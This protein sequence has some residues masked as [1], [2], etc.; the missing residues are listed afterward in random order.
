[1]PLFRDAL[2]VFSNFSGTLIEDSDSSNTISSVLLLHNWNCPWGYNFILNEIKDHSKFMEV[3]FCYLTRDAD[4]AAEWLPTQWIE[5]VWWCNF[6]VI[7]KL[8]LFFSFGQI[9][10]LFSVHILAEFSNSGPSSWCMLGESLRFKCQLGPC[11]FVRSMLDQY[12]HAG[13]RES[14][15]FKIRK[16]RKMYKFDILIAS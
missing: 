6:D 10:N 1:M 14:H 16:V 12:G 13:C 3:R 2:R 11:R 4:H 7:V 9:V 5:Y 15:F 8:L